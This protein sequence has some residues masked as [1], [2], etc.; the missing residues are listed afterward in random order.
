MSFSVNTVIRRMIGYNAG[1]PKRVQHAMKVYAFA[2][3]IAETEP[4]GETEKLILEAAAVL[5]DIGI[6]NSEKKYGS[7]AGKYQEMEG[8]P[9]AE[10]ILR[11]AGCP[12]NMTERICYLIGHHHT[13]RQIDGLDYQ[14]LVEAD[15][16]VNL[17]EDS[18]GSEQAKTVLEKYFKTSVG[19]EY[20]TGMFLNCE[21]EEPAAG[22]KD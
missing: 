14:I 1:D 11:S 13:Y 9:V 3:S 22:G 20:L 6:H 21:R 7:S 4:L 15:F 12:E 2:K 18:L 5:H 8:P 17:Y 19:R 16:L 10:E